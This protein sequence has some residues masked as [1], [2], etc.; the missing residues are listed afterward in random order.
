MIDNKDIVNDDKEKKNKN[1]TII[2]YRKLIHKSKNWKLSELSRA[3]LLIKI[4][5][6]VIFGII[7]GLTNISSILGLIIFAFCFLIVP[8][9]FLEYYLHLNIFQTLD[10][11]ISMLKQ[12]LLIVYLIFLFFWFISNVTK[13]TL[14]ATQS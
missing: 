8:S 6:A 11:P 10:D 13:E 1:L 4:T 12:N 3:F 5:T 14:F 7:F 9:K 2:A